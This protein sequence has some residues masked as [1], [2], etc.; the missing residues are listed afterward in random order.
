MPQCFFMSQSLDNVSRAPV[1]VDYREAKNDKERE[2]IAEIFAQ[3]MT[4]QNL[5]CEA[6]HLKLYRRANSYVACLYPFEKDSSERVVGVM[7]KFEL[8]GR[9]SEIIA[10]L[11]DC[12]EKTNKFVRSINRTIDPATVSS[13]FSA[14]GDRH[15][16]KQK[17][18]NIVLIT[19]SI[20]AIAGLIYF[21]TR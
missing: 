19:I 21:L 10:S 20:G 9:T 15:L 8:P 6:S 4:K 7:A 2:Q 18:K 13:V 1:F 17:T 12:E 11:R 5:L 16:R 14:V 3:V